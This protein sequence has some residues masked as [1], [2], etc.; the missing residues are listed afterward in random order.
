MPNSMKVRET[1]WAPIC[2]RVF[3]GWIG[4]VDIGIELDE[5]ATI[6]RFSLGIIDDAIAPSDPGSLVRPRR[7]YMLAWEIHKESHFG[8]R[9]T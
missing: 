6:V 3:C 2:H 9:R 5:K 7:S 8:Q 4:V 1:C